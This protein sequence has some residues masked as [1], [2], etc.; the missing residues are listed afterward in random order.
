M[1]ALV[2]GSGCASDGNDPDG[3]APRATADVGEVEARWTGDGYLRQFDDGSVELCFGPV[4]PSGPPKVIGCPGITVHADDAVLPEITA[5][6]P[7]VSVRFVGS[8]NASR[9]IL[10]ATDVT[11]G[12]PDQTLERSVAPPNDPTCETTSLDGWGRALAELEPMPIGVLPE[13]SFEMDGSRTLYAAFVSDETF[14]ALCEAQIDVRQLTL[15]DVAR[16]V[17]D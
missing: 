2:V 5:A 4:L 9:D 15:I 7:V 11:V 10:S 17:S 13:L 1:I 3:A 16:P 12:E 8:L 14:D 6:N